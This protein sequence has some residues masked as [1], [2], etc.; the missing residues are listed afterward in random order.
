MLVAIDHIEA[1]ADVENTSRLIDRHGDARGARGS[2]ARCSAAAT[3]PPARRRVFPPSVEPRDQRRQR[4]LFHRLGR[5]DGNLQQPERDALAHALT[6]DQD[7]LGAHE[8]RQCLNG[9]RAADN[10]I[11][12]LR[13]ESGNVVA[14]FLPGR[15]EAIDDVAEAIDRQLVSVEPAD[16]IPPRLTID[17][18]QIAQGA[19]GA[20]EP[21]TRGQS[22][23]LSLRQMAPDVVAQPPELLG[24]RRIGLRN[25][26]LRRSAPN[27]RLTPL[28]AGGARIG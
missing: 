21:I 16:R 4:R 9:D 18:G 6:R 5:P 17:L 20:N 14:P 1:S 3:L 19:S 8:L 2:S 28:P 26:S 23:H 12:S 7:V 13:A 11:G 24:G 15:G 10:R 27:G 22:S 25:F